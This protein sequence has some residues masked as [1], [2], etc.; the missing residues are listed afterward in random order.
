MPYDCLLLRMISRKS[1]AAASFISSYGIL[2][3][4]SFFVI[5]NLFQDNAERPCHPETSSG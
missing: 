1:G 2:V 4:N 3:S 5:L